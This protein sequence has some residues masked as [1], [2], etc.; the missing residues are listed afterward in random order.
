MIK[1]IV[2]DFGGVIADINRD[3]A[4]EAFVQIG[5]KDAD[6]RLDKYHQTGI[7]QELEEGKITDEAFRMELEKLCGRSLTWKETQQAWLGFM[8]GVDTRKLQYLEQLRV[9]GYNLYILS[10]TNPY[11]MGWACSK[12]FTPLG[13]PL[14]YYFKKLYL[15]YRVGYTKPDKEIFEYMIS[16]SGILPQETV[17]V[18]DGKSN[19][20]IAQSLG[21]HTVQPQNA[22]DWRSLLSQTLQRL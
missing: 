16:D 19:I 10:N 6:A 5:L 8:I 14:S 18:D 2:F 15:S 4:V 11:V 21:F 7:F 17:F 9:E 1:N 20:D 13:R 12:D 22:T 3:R